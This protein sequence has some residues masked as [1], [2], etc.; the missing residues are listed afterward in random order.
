[1]TL[2][3][4]HKITPY[5]EE[6]DDA[7]RQAVADGV[8]VRC[9]A[10]LLNRSRNSVLGR[11]HRIGARFGAATPTKPISPQHQDPVRVGQHEPWLNQNMS[12]A[13][14]IHHD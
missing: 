13:V 6:E 2:Y 8:T 4:G 7:I 12:A 9:C 5:T 1:M 11:G 14:S 3:N 10:R